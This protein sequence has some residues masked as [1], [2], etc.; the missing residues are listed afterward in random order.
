MRTPRIHRVWAQHV[1]SNFYHPKKGADI[2]K[3]EVLVENADGNIVPA[4]AK[5]SKA[6]LKAKRKGVE[7]ADLPEDAKPVENLSYARKP[8]MFVRPDNT[9]R[10]MMRKTA[11][12]FAYEQ[13]CF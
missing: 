11:Y 13:D 7:I 10:N 9:Y 12:N 5:I 2:V 8:N 6:Q 3:E 4:D 1:K